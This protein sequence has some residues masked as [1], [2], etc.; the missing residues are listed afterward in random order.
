MLIIADREVR[1][2]M[3]PAAFLPGEG[4]GNDGLRDIEK[5]LELEDLQ[6]LRIN[7]RPLSCTVTDKARWVSAVSAESAADMD[8]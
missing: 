5:G 7:T 1:P 6:E 3:S 8:S 2:V 4:A